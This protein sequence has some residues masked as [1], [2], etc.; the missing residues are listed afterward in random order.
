MPVN[1]IVT[2][3]SL[4]KRWKLSSTSASQLSSS[5]SSAG[6]RSPSRTSFSICTSAHT[7]YLPLSVSPLKEQQHFILELN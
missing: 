6:R 3:S 7:D 4:G 2:C 1:G 5:G